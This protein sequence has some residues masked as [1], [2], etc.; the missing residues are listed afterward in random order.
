MIHIFFPLNT[1]HVS[2]IFEIADRILPVVMTRS[3]GIFFC[4]V[5]DSTFEAI[6]FE[7]RFKFS[8]MHHGW[9]FLERN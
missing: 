2:A 6:E 3:L 8:L 1:F 7:L 9:M 4:K 5:L